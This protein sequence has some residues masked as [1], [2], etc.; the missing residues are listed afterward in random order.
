MLVKISITVHNSTFRTNV[1]FIIYFAHF[2][3]CKYDH[4]PTTNAIA[5]TNHDH[6]LSTSAIT[7]QS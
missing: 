3:Y 2:C 5:K 4:T 6:S 1:R 7:S